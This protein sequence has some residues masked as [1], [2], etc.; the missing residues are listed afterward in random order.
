MPFLDPDRIF[1][2]SRSTVRINISTIWENPGVV[3][4]D[5]NWA[6]DLTQSQVRIKI[7]PGHGSWNVRLNET[8]FR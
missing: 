1:L 5:R 2:K 8:S 7:G 6:V 3:F 4:P